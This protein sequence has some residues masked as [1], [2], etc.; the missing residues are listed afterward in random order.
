MAVGEAE[1]PPPGGPT[2]DRVRR[3]STSA[4]RSDEAVSSP[5][6]P[7]FMRT[8][9]P[10]EP[11]TPTA[12]SS[13]REP[14]VRAPAREHRQGDG[15]ARAHRDGAVG[16]ARRSRRSPRTPPR[17]RPRARGTRDPTRAG[18]SPGRRRAAAT[19]RP[20]HRRGHALEVGH[21]ARLDQERGGPADAVGRPRPERG[22]ALG[23][24]A[25]PLGE[26]RRASS[27]AP[28]PQLVGRAS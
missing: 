2:H 12:H 18:W 14:L 6:P 13:P 15:A 21:R 24:V 25:E 5:W 17:G 7:A 4:V 8:A 27:R 1:R 28:A 11:G 22:V 3:S 16:R 23:Q 26:R 9:P 10:T 19:S 20:V